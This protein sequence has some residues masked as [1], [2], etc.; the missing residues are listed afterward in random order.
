MDAVLEKLLH[1][2]DVK[3]FVEQRWNQ[4][5]L[6][7]PGDRS[8]IEALQIGFDLNAFKSASSKLRDDKLATIATFFDRA[9]AHSQLRIAADQIDELLGA[10]MSIFVVDIARA[11]GGLAQLGASVREELGF[12]GRLEINAYASAPSGGTGIHFDR[13]G[14]LTLQLTGTKTWRYADEPSTPHPRSSYVR[15]HALAD[16]EF[17]ARYPT[18]RIDVPPEASLR[19]VTLGPGDVLYLPG[20][21]WHQT[22]AST[23]SLSLGLTFVPLAAIDGLTSA[24]VKLLEDDLG[25]RKDLP[26]CPGGSLEPLQSFVEE[27]LAACRQLL[28]RTTAAEWSPLLAGVHS[29][30]RAS[31]ATIAPEDRLEPSAPITYET[32]TDPDDGSSMLEVAAGA[33]RVLIDP[34]ALPFVSKLTQADVFPAH[35]ASEWMPALPWDE[36]SELLGS[37]VDSGL[38]R[39][40]N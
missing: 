25:W 30:Q 4:R 8:K 36:L 26:L 37:L 16:D 9:G 33:S 21:T 14:V 10:G 35:A 19:T 12:M 24:L 7:I 6:Y 13:P 18:H 34:E 22:A 39:V 2:I 38:L 40:V 28:A 17:R 5:S 27:R 23:D 32:A 29:L 31:R 15:V 1:P 20:G 11:D 3:A